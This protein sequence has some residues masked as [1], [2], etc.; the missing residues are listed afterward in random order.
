MNLLTTLKICFSILGISI[1]LIGCIADK[2]N[3]NKSEI[4][5]FDLTK[6]TEA[7]PSLPLSEIAT[8][9]NYIPLETTDSSLLGTIYNII[10]RESSFYVHSRDAIFRF[11]EK[12]K[13]LGKIE[14]VGKGPEEYSVI[15]DFDISPSEDLI[16]IL[17]WGKILYYN[18]T[19][20]F[21]NSVRHDARFINFVDDQRVLTYQSNMNGDGKYSQIIM[22]F[23]G[24]TIKSIPNKFQF[25]LKGK[26]MGLPPF[27][28]LRY[29]FSD[30]FFISDI[31]DDTLYRVAKNNSLVP[32]AIFY[33]GD[34]RL[35]AEERSKG[36]E[37]FKHFNDFICLTNLLES[38]RYIYYTYQN[39]N[40]IYDKK[41]SV[42][43]EFSTIQNDIDGGIN[44][45][46]KY[47]WSSDGFMVSMDV[48][49]IKEHIREQTFKNAEVIDLKGKQ[50]FEQFVNELSDND[51]PVIM[52]VN[53]KD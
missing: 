51:N 47:A 5:F 40:R 53:L 38:S 6:S 29:R 26:T 32:Y 22:N 24:D 48:L 19:G 30:S 21:Q 41:R 11:N 8:S 33:S 12:G 25:E 2:K 37:M 31:Q 16:A 52:I 27:E 35:T 17:T 50:K 23:G 45:K 9:I 39:K 44:F 42:T 10:K 18:T 20:E 7:K 28:F 13:F 1:F 3:E 14:R 46:P 36:I 43:Y 15:K 34:H 49:K 4:Y